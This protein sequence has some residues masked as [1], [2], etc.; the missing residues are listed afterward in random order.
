MWFCSQAKLNKNTP[1]SQDTKS[2]NAPTQSVLK[3]PFR[4]DTC[5]F[6]STSEAAMKVHVNCHIERSD[7]VFKCFYCPFYV[8]TKEYVF[9]LSLSAYSETCHPSNYV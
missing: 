8:S 6:V 4:C 1:D 7:V 2:S 5:P 3:K 9:P